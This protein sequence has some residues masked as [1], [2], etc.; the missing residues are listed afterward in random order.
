MA[1]TDYPA[2]YGASVPLINNLDVAVYLD[3]TTSAS[4]EGIDANNRKPTSFAGLKDDDGAAS[5]DG[6]IG[7]DG[8]P[9]TSTER[10]FPA[11]YESNQS[12]I[13][14]VEKIIL[15]NPKLGVTYKVRVFAN[16]ALSSAQ[17]YAL[18]I[19]GNLQDFDSSV[20]H[21][22]RD[23]VVRA[24]RSVTGA[25]PGVKYESALTIGV[26]FLAATALLCILHR[27]C[28]TRRRRY[29]TTYRD[30]H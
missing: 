14:T 7:D 8:L 13:N 21:G 24:W 4:S 29:Y 11:D 3:S 2:A 26:V 22:F 10:Y 27:M 18:V 23:K 15:N 28:I 6:E 1:Y 16:G 20:D 19:S 17:P 25:M 5:D 30:E 9:I 12:K